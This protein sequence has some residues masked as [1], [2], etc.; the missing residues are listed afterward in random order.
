MT[1]A[2]NLVLPTKEPRS[3]L[4]AAQVEALLSFLAS[5]TSNAVA[6]RSYVAFSRILGPVS[7]EDLEG[8]Y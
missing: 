7:E 3:R 6:V 8:Y 1:P 4:G 5:E 2:E